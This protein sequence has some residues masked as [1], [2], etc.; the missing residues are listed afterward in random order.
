[1]AKDVLK[2]DDEFLENFI[3]VFILKK[4]MNLELMKS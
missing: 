2:I 1:M 4:W 3:E